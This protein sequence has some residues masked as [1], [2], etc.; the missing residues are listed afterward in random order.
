MMRVGLFDIVHV[1]TLTSQNRRALLTTRWL[2]Q[3]RAIDLENE[4][5]G[6]L[7]NFGLKVGN[8]SGDMSERSILELVET[9]LIWRKSWSHC[10]PGGASCKKDL[11]S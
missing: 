7:R 1:K 6:L 10:S 3:K 4:M 5:G 9:T 8:S 2:L 11:P